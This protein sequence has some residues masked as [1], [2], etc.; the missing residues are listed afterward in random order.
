MS[1]LEV[2][3]ILSLLGINIMVY[4]DLVAAC[5]SNLE[6]RDPARLRKLEDDWWLDRGKWACRSR[7]PLP[8]PLTNVIMLEIDIELKLRR[9]EAGRQRYTHPELQE[10][11]FVDQS[12]EPIKPNPFMRSPGTYTS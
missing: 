12:S 2:G 10:E 7:L 3:I 4:G 9:E 1:T 6:S 11:F 5:L 8:P